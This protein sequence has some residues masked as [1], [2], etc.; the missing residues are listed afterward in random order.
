MPCGDASWGSG[1]SILIQQTL[2][3]IF[4][5]PYL[6]VERSDDLLQRAYRLEPQPE[7]EPLFTD[8]E[9]AAHQDD[10]PLLLRLSPGS[11]LFDAYS[12]APGDW[13]GLLLSTIQPASTVLAHLR[14]LLIV[15]FGERRKA[16]LRYYD[17]RVASYFFPA[18]AAESSTTW[19]GPIHQLN[20]HGGTWRDAAQGLSQWH[21]LTHPETRTTPPV[22][23]QLSARQSRAIE[24]QQLERFTYEWQQARKGV[25]FDQ[26]WDYL[27]Q[28]LACGFD[29]HDSLHA[30][31]D[32]R[33]QYP[34]HDVH[35]IPPTGDA[36]ERLQLLRAHL[37]APAFKKQYT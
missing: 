25:S 5:Q 13:P 3:A 22:P 21:Q 20:W 19:L 32:L 7:P 8:T 29:E 10:G 33:I 12:K 34:A 4:G 18:C 23:L 2:Q 1:M 17:P 14:R 36:Q 28:G 15:G 26:A 31:L 27:Q 37:E 9:L 35:P 30:Y 6:L 11:A 16:L 24:H